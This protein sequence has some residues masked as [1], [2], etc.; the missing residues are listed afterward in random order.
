M[1]SKTLLFGSLDPQGVVPEEARP[2]E[3]G[4]EAAGFAPDLLTPKRSQK[5][6]GFTY[7]RVV[8]NGGMDHDDSPYKPLPSFRANPP[9][10]IIYSSVHFLVPFLHFLR[11]FMFWLSAG[12]GLPHHSPIPW[13]CRGDEDPR[14]GKTGQSRA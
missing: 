8:G 4:A 1:G 3:A 14:K 7:R 11:R 13:Q 10:Y 12:A 2:L 5:R 9:P 6:L